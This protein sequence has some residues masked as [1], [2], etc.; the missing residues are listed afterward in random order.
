MYSSNIKAELRDAR[1]SRWQ[2]KLLKLFIIAGTGY[3]AGL[4]TIFWIASL[5]N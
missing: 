2:D 5:T 1:R 4:S 3:L